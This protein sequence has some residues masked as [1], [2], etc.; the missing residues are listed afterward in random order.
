MPAQTPVERTTDP[1]AIRSFREDGLSGESL[2][3]MRVYVAVS[4][5]LIMA[6]LSTTV[7]KCTC[8]PFGPCRL[9]V[10]RKGL[11]V[12]VTIGFPSSSTKYTSVTSLLGMVTSPFSRVIWLGSFEAPWVIC[13]SMGGGEVIVFTVF[14]GFSYV[15]VS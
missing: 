11:L 2:R 1:L 12:R 9:G 13:V 8:S 14:V 4:I 10:V 7:R 6:P 5:A 15:E 3:A